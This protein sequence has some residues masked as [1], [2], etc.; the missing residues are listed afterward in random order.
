MNDM[1][2]LKDSSYFA[3]ALMQKHRIPTAKTGRI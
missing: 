1:N 3:E 2:K